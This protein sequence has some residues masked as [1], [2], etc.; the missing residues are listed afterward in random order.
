M[1]GPRPKA[2]FLFRT[3]NAVCSAVKVAISSAERNDSSETAENVAGSS[4]EGD[5]SSVKKEGR[6]TPPSP[7]TEEEIA[8]G[9]GAPW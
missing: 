5:D 7:S 8:G 2:A 6:V 9:E 3:R 1:M 4:A